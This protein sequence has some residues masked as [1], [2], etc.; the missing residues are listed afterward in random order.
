MS[1]EANGDKYDVAI[2][3][4]VQDLQFAQALRDELVKSLKVFFFPHNQEE[5]AGTN[6]LETMRAPFLNGSRVNVVIFRERWGNT[7][8]TRVESTAIQE[9]CLQNGWAGLFFYM[10]DSSTPPVWLPSTHVRFNAS[11]FSVDQAVGAIK[12]RVQEQGGQLEPMTPA[13]LVELY[14][15]DE[16]YNMALSSLSSQ[17]SI[18]EIRA[19][20]RRLFDLLGEGVDAIVASGYE[21][22]K[23][24]APIA[25]AHASQFGFLLSSSTDAV[26]VSWT[27]PYT[28]SLEHASLQVL[29]FEQQLLL[30]AEMI[31]RY[32]I[33][34]PQPVRTSKFKPWLSRTREHI[35]RDTKDEMLTSEALRDFLIMQFVEAMRKRSARR[36]GVQ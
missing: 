15:A 22:L 11:D 29:E 5:L 6:G 26:N 20:A 32:Y 9:G 25:Q 17:S 21:D 18:T 3:F 24:E 36:W 31:G 14:R 10:A 8:W 30:S 35:W 16:S 23:W 27:Q 13:K 34:R 12:A 33:E 7:P 2:S 19:E 1:A 28:N 4:L